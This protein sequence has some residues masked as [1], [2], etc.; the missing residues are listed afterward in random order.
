MYKDDARW[1]FGWLD[2]NGANWSFRVPTISLQTT[3]NSNLEFVTGSGWFASKTTMIGRYSVDGGADRAWGPLNY[4]SSNALAV[5]QKDMAGKWSTDANAGYGMAFE[6]DADGNLT[7]STTGALIGEC[8][9]TGSVLQTEP[10]TSHN[11]FNLKITATNSATRPSDTA[12]T[13]EQGEEY[14]GL[15]AVYMDPVSTYPEEGAYRT[16]IFHGGTV[17]GGFL[18]NF[19]RK[20]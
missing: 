3:S 12:C 2:V 10:A 11:M 19:L 17:T 5:Q 20:R 7:G 9:L 14:D 16:L 6:M 15:A 4:S 1:V 8:S 13:M 18:T